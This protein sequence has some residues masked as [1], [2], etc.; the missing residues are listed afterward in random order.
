MLSNVKSMA[1]DGLEG[2]LIEIQT[3]VSNGIPKFEVVGL[4]D[5]SIKE[6][7]E[8]VRIAIKNLNIDIPSRKIL[9]NLA[10]A[11]RRKE[12][13]VFDLPIAIGILTAIGIIKKEKFEDFDRTIFLGELSLDG[14]INRVKGVLP[15]CI[16]ASNLGIKKVILPK[17]NARE[18]A[19]VK[20]L[21]IIPVSSLQEVIDFINGEINIKRLNVD[22]NKI[23]KNKGKYVVDFSEVKGQENV[24]R[25]LEI[26]TAGFHNCALIGSL[27]SGKS[28][29]AQRIPTIL[30]DITFKE[31]LEITKIHSIAGNIKSGDSIVKSRPFRNPHYTTST[32][33][34]IGGGRIP[35]PGEIS[36]AHLG[37]LY[38]DELPEF[39]SNALEALREPL[40]DK[41][42]TISR[43]NSTLTYPC[44]FMLIASMNPCKCGYYGTDESK[45][46]CSE[47]SINKYLSKVSGPLLDRI[48]LHIEVKPVKYK[49]LD[50]H[51]KGETSKQIKERVDR[52]RNIQLNRYKD[53]N[54]Y[55]NGELSHNLIERFCV[56]DENGKQLL[57]KAFNNLGLSARAYDKI[58]KISRTIADLDG[59][60]NI[61][62]NHIAEAIQ[63]RSLDRKYWKK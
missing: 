17:A 13:T 37:V 7:K 61:M 23:L 26:A 46:T 1:L 18:A 44:N 19:V 28:M 54:I 50:S 30:P 43:L 11:D 36:L 33:S 25:A 45:C 22:I 53:F 6:A 12:G 5:T 41:I 34:I 56:I 16:E 60:E 38:L 15:M 2:D 59:E 24:K 57:K 29:L 8:R 14:K 49:N 35:K 62:P 51:E 58:L 55:T 39:N 10:P 48:D 42:V 47:Q 4:P 21:E 9:I 63:Y 40:E 52:A 31:A 32:I 27:G 20:E 3:E